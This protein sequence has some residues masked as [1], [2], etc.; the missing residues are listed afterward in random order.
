MLSWLLARGITEVTHPMDHPT[1][2][3]KPLTFT[4]LKNKVKDHEIARV[5]E[6]FPDEKDKHEWNNALL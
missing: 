2:A 6:Q 4:E 5:K 1:K 3:G